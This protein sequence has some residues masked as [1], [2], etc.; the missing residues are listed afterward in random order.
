MKEKLK[1]IL[2]LINLRV[3]IKILLWILWLIILGF[4]SLVIYSFTYE[5]EKI[6]I[7]RYNFE[8]LEKAKP[9]LE[10]ID[11]N[12]EDFYFLPDFN[13]K[14]NIDIK[15]IKNCYY[16]RSTNGEYQYIFWF[17]LESLLYKKIYWTEFYAYPEYDVPS[18]YTWHVF[19]NQTVDK[20]MNPDVKRR[21]FEYIISNPCED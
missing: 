6:E 9:Y 2:K 18:Y 20:S 4:I 14:F 1:K 8:Q 16:V 12:T 5:K 21:A 11:E 10:T 3:V 7:D 15:P 13:E 19:P 17:K